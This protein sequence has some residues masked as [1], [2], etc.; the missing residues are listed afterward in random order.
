MKPADSLTQPGVR[1]CTPAALSAEDIS[2]SSAGARCWPMF[3]AIDGRR[4]G[5]MAKIY[6]FIGKQPKT[7]GEII[8]EVMARR[9][10]KMRRISHVASARATALEP[11]SYD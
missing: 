9:T 3:N 4:V 7:H 10:E 6:E 11:G 2:C 5:S 1:D 8:R